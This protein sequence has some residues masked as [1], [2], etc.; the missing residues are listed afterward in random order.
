MIN[1]S[2]E[3]I[4]KAVRERY[5]RAAAPTEPAERAAEG[6]CC[7]PD[8]CSSQNAASG[9]QAETRAEA[10]DAE[11]LGYSKAELDAIP[12]GAYTGLGCGNPIAH[13]E[14][15]LGSVVVDLGSGAGV[16]CFLA[17]RRTGETGRVIG[18]D[19]TPEM[20]ERARQSAAEGEWANVEFRLGEIEALPVADGMADLVISNCVV[21]LSP[22]KQAVFRE[23]SR[24]L[25]PGGELVLT[26]ILASDELPGTLRQDLDAHA[27]CLSGAV[28]EEATRAMLEGAGFEELRIEPFE[29]TRALIEQW[30]D[31][32]AGSQS[33]VSALVRARKP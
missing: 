4:R 18:V 33:V 7:G 17:A 32:A 27:A 21:N 15:T 24:V 23:A 31:G 29:E 13:A 20:I 25:R 22:D 6:S 5:A 30:V 12:E 14:I 16:D 10:P 2:G 3:S 19:M 28:T 1:P 9:A 8:C 26:D 11:H